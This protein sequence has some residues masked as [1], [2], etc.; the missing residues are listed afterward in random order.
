MAVTAMP[1][2][3]SGP[4]GSV[5]QGIVRYAECS[6]RLNGQTRA[7][8][9][10]CPLCFRVLTVRDHSHRCGKSRARERRM[11]VR[12]GESNRGEDSK[13]VRGNVSIS[14]EADDNPSLVLRAAWYGA[15]ALGNIVAFFNPKEPTAPFES[16][17]T[18]EGPSSREYVVKSIVDDYDKGYFVTGNVTTGIYEED[19]EF[20]DPAGSFK[21]L[22]RFKNNCS[23]FGSLLE[24]SDVK[25]MKSEEQEEKF[26]AYW[27]FSCVLKF[28]WRPILSST[29][30]TEYY[31][32]SDS[33]RI[34]RHVENWDVP[35][36]ALLGQV[37]KPNPSFKK[38]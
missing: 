9:R 32:N 3:H 15:E 33:G 31:F 28:P 35:K 19:C 24:R 36:M 37:F 11:V 23:N 13:S 20:A 26:V 25:L 17:D 16:T 21:S 27:R 18:L 38:R 5:A 29:G 34:C 12:A 10:L 7:M 6:S 14:S 2:L 8:S 30:F 1:S 4:C 22:Q